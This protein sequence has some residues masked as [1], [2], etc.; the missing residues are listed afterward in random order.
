MEDL[1]PPYDEKYQHPPPPP[2]NVPVVTPV[3]RVATV[4]NKE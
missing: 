3:Y 4:L 2:P 1:P